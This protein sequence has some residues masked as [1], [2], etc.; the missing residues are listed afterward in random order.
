MIIGREKEQR[1]LHGLLEKRN[2]SFV[3]SMVEGA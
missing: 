3:L 1:E 2:R